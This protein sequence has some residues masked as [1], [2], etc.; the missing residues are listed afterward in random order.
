MNVVSIL[1]SC[2]IDVYLFHLFF[3]NYFT[4]REQI[5]ENILLEKSIE[6]IALL[7][8]AVCN[9]FGNGYLNILI[10][11][12]LLFLYAVVAFRGKIKHKLLCLLTVFCIL[13]GCE[14]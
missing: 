1:L 6:C 3:S 12:I 14:L 11:P 2:V 8:L 9:F 7:F 10:T 5:S 13:Y 4:K